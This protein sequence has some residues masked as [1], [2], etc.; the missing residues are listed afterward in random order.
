MRQTSDPSIAI[1]I[2]IYNEAEN[3]PQIIRRVDEV[4]QQ[5]GHEYQIICVDDGS[6]DSSGQHLEGFE[7]VKVIRHETNR[8]YGA[9]LQTG[10]EQARGFDY[11]AFLDADA[12]YPPRELKRLLR[13]MQEDHSAMMCIGSRMVIPNEMEPLRK[14]G[15]RLYAT[16][17]QLFFGSR[18]TDVCS[19]MRVFRA[20]LLSSMDWS[21]LSDDL[22]F[23][24]QLTSRCLCQR[25]R[26]V[27]IP[28]DYRER[29]GHSKLK[30]FH[31][32][33]RFL[34]SILRERL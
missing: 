18:L 3:L 12:T 19:G 22:D 9:A 6:S 8:G 16:L 20:D 21:G 10:F 33:W 4:A 34:G 23:S 31:H 13:R 17:C 15:N 7:G 25:I 2:P 28:I 5:T 26:V 24:P 29:G 32:G 1:V 11:V 30:I 27:E 14:I